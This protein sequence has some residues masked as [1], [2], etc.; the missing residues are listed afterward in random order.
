MS[1]SIF[2]ITSILTVFQIQTNVIGTYNVIRE[3]TKLI[4]KNQPDKDGFRGVIV[5]TA[6]SEAI[7][8]QSGQAAISAA[9]NAIICM[10]K[11]LAALRKKQGI[12]VVTISP[13]LI[14]TPLTDYFP[15]DIEQAL[16]M[17]CFT[18]PNRMGEPD[19]FAH[20]VQTVVMGS[21]INGTNINITGGMH[22]I[23]A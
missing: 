18:G 19:E 9:S 2:S 3:T 10:T 4:E 6:G 12:R 21:H 7:R 22:I 16:E 1:M 23:M 15:P 20:M 5:N 11:P 13:G 8:G 14:R 17:T